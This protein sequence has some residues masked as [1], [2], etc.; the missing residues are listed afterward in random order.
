MTNSSSLYKAYIFSVLVGVTASVIFIMGAFKFPYWAIEI[1]SIFHLALAFLTIVMILRTRNIFQQIGKVS[2]AVKLGNF[3]HRADTLGEKGEVLQVIN[4]FN[5]MI[6]ANDAFA[7]ETDLAMSASSQGR[8]YR[9]ILLRGFCG[10]HLTS[11]KGINSSIDVMA[12]HDENAKGAVAETNALLKSMKAGVA[13]TSEILSALSNLDLT[14]RM[15]GEYEGDFASLQNDVNAVA[16]KLNGIVSQLRST[17]GGLKTATGEI[18]EGANDLSDRT[19]KQAATIEQ[20][21]AA[22][23]QLSSTVI[24]NAQKAETASIKSHAVSDAAEQ[25]G[26]VMHQAKDAMERIASSSEK[27][28]NIIGMIDDIAFQTNLLALNAS[29]EAARAGEAGKG[30][31]VVAIEVRRLAQSA[32]EA[33]SEIKMLIEQSA[34]E[35]KGGSSLVADAAI[36]LEKMMLAIKENG[37][38]LDAIAKDS[39]EQATSIEEVHGAINIMDEMTQHNA[40]LVE[41]T[42]AAIEQTEGQASELDRIVDEF[43]VAGD[44][45]YYDSK[46]VAA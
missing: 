5:S 14:K 13:E 29:V 7:R 25:S 37:E 40:A 31:A 4:N 27:I 36:K 43:E 34:N 22:M 21:S 2:K 39:K 38:L 33:S 24:A 41:Q 20:T 18:L 23:E 44:K 9:K 32:A 15:K 30:F 28:S 16:D 12:N 19:T 45:Q 11:A 17:S 42:N 46:E 3:H 10:L 35:V 8:Y 1:M 26:Q 6:D